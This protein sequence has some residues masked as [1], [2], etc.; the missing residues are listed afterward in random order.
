MTGCTA[1]E[2]VVQEFV[3]WWD[4]QAEKFKGGDQRNRSVTL[5]VAGENGL[6]DRM[7]LSRWRK[8]LG[9]PEAF[10]RTIAKAAGSFFPAY[11][12]ST[13]YGDSFQITGRGRAQHG[14]RGDTWA[15]ARMRGITRGELR[16]ELHALEQR[17]D[18]RFNARF[19]DIND[20]LEK[21]NKAL[22]V[23]LAQRGR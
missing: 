14:G 20:A 5:L 2:D 22:D 1:D 23:L 9:T 12:E 15:S 16:E 10:E 3:F 4:T 19:N 17:L 7:T 13:T 6:P 18:T 21:V 8:R 11:L